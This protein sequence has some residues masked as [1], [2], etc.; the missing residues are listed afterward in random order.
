MSTPVSGKLVLGVIPLQGLTSDKDM[1]SSKLSFVEETLFGGRAFWGPM[2]MRRGVAP[3]LEGDTT[4]PQVSQFGFQC[5][6][7]MPLSNLACTPSTLL[8][9]NM[10][11]ERLSFLE[12]PPLSGA[13]FGF[14]V[15]P[16]EVK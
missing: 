13:P 12:E 14:H 15:D 7:S 16:K 2:L 11:P 10:A 5:P 6:T 8:Q 4:V 9:I 3:H 1:A